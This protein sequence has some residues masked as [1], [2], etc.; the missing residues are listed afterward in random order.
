MYSHLCQKVMCQIWKP[1][2]LP[3]ATS[4]LGGTYE[5]IPSDYDCTF[6]RGLTVQVS[7]LYLLYRPNKS[8]RATG[9]KGPTGFMSR[10]GL[11]ASVTNISFVPQSMNK[12]KM[13]PCDLEPFP[14]I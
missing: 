9:S 10:L 8:I 2:P 11:K 4:C 14:H 3:E 12:I 7:G 1:H 13:T 5:I 6:F